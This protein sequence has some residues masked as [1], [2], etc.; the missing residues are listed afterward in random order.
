MLDALKRKYTQHEEQLTKHGFTVFCLALSWLVSWA[1]GRA[2]TLWNAATHYSSNSVLYVVVFAGAFF[3]LRR[4]LRVQDRRIKIASASLGALFSLFLLLGRALERHNNITSLVF[5]YDGVFQTQMLRT[6]FMQFLGLLVLFGAVLAILFHYFMN[7]NPK[8]K[9]FEGFW[10]FNGKR[11]FFII[12]AIIFLCWVPYFLLQYPGVVTFDTNM[13][14]RQI[15]GMSPWNNHHPIIHTLMMS[16]FIHLGNAIFG[17]LQGGV[18]LL[19]IFQMLYMSAA[20]AFAVQFLARRQFHR[21]VPIAALA[22][23]A[24]FP[25]NGYYSV[26]HWKDQPFAVMMLLLTMALAEIIRQREAFF[27]KAGN[28]AWFLGSL[29]GVMLLRNNGLYVLLL[30]FPLLLIFLKPL[31]RQMLVAAGICAIVFTMY[32]GPVF[33]LLNA[34]RGSAAEA[35]SIPLQQLAR[36]ARHHWEDLSEEDQ[37]VFHAMFPDVEYH[38]G[39]L[40]NP[41][42]SDPVKDNF[43]MEWFGENQTEFLCFWFRMFPQHSMEYVNAFLSNNF[44]YWYP[45]VAHWTVGTQ[46]LHHHEL[47]LEHRTPLPRLHEFFHEIRLGNMRQVPGIS[48]F[49]SIGFHFWLLLIAT[50]LMLLK[51]RR[52]ELL[53]FA[54]VFLLW[55]TCLAS[56]VHAEFRY[57][58][59]MFTSL[60]VLLPLALWS[61]KGGDSFADAKQ[62]G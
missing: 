44:G 33:S 27:K 54:P 10:A 15:L 35:M 21:L 4:G 43:C 30:V 53:I 17:S 1:F 46:G 38:I 42:L 31:R 48:M 2:F 62:G 25:I 3:L 20:F 55:L 40:Y 11:S 18:A 22:W 61:K 8:I 7:R 29:V 9:L 5:D 45:E 19:S 51:K 23:F 12:W 49:Y 6:A 36:V 37:A 58:Y 13:Q 50:V 57:I 39:N 47:A 34:Q 32:R 56:P 60:P 14:I 41:R 52:R 24:L 59:G 16:V 28:W 26:T